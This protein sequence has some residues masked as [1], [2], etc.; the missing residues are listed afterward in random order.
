MNKWLSYFLTETPRNRTDKDDILPPLVTMSGMSVPSCSVSPEN[1]SSRGSIFPLPG[2]PGADYCGDCGGGYWIRLATD[3]PL[4]CGRCFPSE[5][6]VETLLVPGGTV[7]SCTAS[8]TSQPA[9]EGIQIEPAA[10]NAKAIYWE[11]G[12]GRILGPAVPEFLARD[13][14]TFWISTAFEG[15]IRW[16]NADRLR[17]R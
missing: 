8:C 9:P 16:I 11:T 13:G 17:S 15:Q 10:R 3:T 6:R 12:T 2:E 1:S 4:Q 5:T 14:S 7:P